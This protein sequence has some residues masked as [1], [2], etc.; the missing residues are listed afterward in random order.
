MKTID[1][2]TV[3]L[4]STDDNV[5]SYACVRAHTQEELRRNPSNTAELS[6]VS[7]NQE[8]IT[9]TDTSHTDASTIQSR[10][11]NLP[12]AFAAEKYTAQ[13]MQAWL[14]ERCIFDPHAVTPFAELRADWLKWA[15]AND[16]YSSTAH[17]LAKAL[18]HLGLDRCV[19]GSGT[20]RSYVGI[21][22]KVGGAA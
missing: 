20:Q 4:C 15:Q 12:D 6:L 21:A 11:L 2:V 22:L 10:L 19:L 17:R 8:G 13:A 14:Q 9:M 18:C 16:R 7:P 3:L 5:S 1:P